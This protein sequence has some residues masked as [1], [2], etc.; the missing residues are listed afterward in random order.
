TGESGPQDA[1][2]DAAVHFA[3][4][5][6]LMNG[7]FDDHDSMVE[8]RKQ[9]ECAIDARPTFALANIRYAQATT[10]AE[11]P[12]LKEGSAT[13][14]ISKDK[15]P[16]IHKHEAQAVH[17]I[18]ELGFTVPPSLKVNLGWESILIGFVQ[19]DQHA[20]A[21]AIDLSNQA[22]NE[23]PD[24]LTP[25]FNLALALLAHGKYDDAI[26]AYHAAMSL[27]ANRPQTLLSAI[28]D[29]DILR[30]SCPSLN[31]AAY[32]DRVNKGINSLKSQ[33]VAAAYNKDAKPSGVTLN[34]SGVTLVPLQIS[35]TPS[36][37]SWSV[38]NARFSLLDKVHLI[39]YA[40]N[41][42]WRTWRVLPRISGPVLGSQGTQSYLRA[43]AGETCV[44]P[45]KYRAELYV[46]D[47]L[48]GVQEAEQP[49]GTFTPAS[50]R[51]LNMAACYP[52]TW[53]NWQTP[54]LIHFERGF[55]DP[56]KRRGL[57][58]FT[59]FNPNGTDNEQIKRQALSGAV[60]EL[61]A[62]GLVTMPLSGS[63]FNSCNGVPANNSLLAGYLTQAGEL[64]ARAWVTSDKLAHAAVVI[65]TH[66][67]NIG[68]NCAVL[69][70]VDNL[71]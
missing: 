49:I 68:E 38:P 71:N 22:I 43:S 56:S 24:D 32:C 54:S 69:M 46:N 1:A 13:S 45:G 17:A 47:V 15:L 48:R 51:T 58:L 37:F 16:D 21:D 10:L 8:A 29:L 67:S 3:Q 59:F 28:T 19:H 20:L 30:A 52:T 66:A 18:E 62:D 42:D 39:W 55:L 12:Q 70:S 44:E 60:K 2:H 33:L 11:T 25:R 36:H 26:A 53:K 9:F 50:F 31:P 6:K 35:V 64:L 65:D 7:W 23:D 40:Y 27:P 61:M 5:N 63:R 4:G 57:F 34:A 41:P 14:L